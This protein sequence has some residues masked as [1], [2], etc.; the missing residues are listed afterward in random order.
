MGPAPWPQ[1]GPPAAVT[2]DLRC[3]VSSSREW[4]N[5]SCQQPQALLQHLRPP[6][7]STCTLAPLLSQWLDAHHL[8]SRHRHLC[9]SL[10]PRLS[11]PGQ[12]WPVCVAHAPALLILHT[13]WALVALG[14]L[15][16]VQASSQAR[17]LGTRPR[18]APLYQLM[19]GFGMP[20]TRQ[21]SFTVSPS[22]AVQLASS[23]SKSGAPEETQEH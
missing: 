20:V 6:C 15:C 3:T 5:Q 2:L 18:A 8:T 4:G 19:T 11:A 1:P 22:S 10:V 7:L 14:Q 17:S 21:A 23:S 16:P 12:V 13:A 9:S